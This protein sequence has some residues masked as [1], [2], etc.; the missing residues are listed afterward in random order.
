MAD[1][2][3]MPILRDGPIQSIWMKKREGNRSAGQWRFYAAGMSSLL[4]HEKAC[5]G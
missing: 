5:A 1:G 2:T 3:F 4:I